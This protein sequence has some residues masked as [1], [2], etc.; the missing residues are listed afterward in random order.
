V[1]ADLAVVGARRG[2]EHLAAHVVELHDP[3]AVVAPPLLGLLLVVH[4]TAVFI[5]PR[6]GQVIDAAFPSICS[7]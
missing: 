5:H 7:S 2:G 4:L 1:T 6:M 3:L